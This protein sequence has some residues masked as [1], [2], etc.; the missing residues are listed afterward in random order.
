MTS[1]CT[2]H[3]PYVAAIADGE[4]ELVPAEHRQHVAECAGCAAE[5]AIQRE[6]TEGLRAARTRLKG[7]PPQRI[8]TL[9]WRWSRVGL[10]AAA[11]AVAIAAGAG[12]AGWRAAV[13][14]EQPISVAMAAAQRSP[15]FRSSDPAA[16]AEWCSRQSDRM[17]PIV[18]ITGLLPIGARLDRRAGTAVVTVFYLS[19]S[20]RHVA[21][22]WIDPHLAG[23]GGEVRQETIAGHPALVVETPRGTAVVDGELPLAQLRSVAG[24]LREQPTAVGPQRA[25]RSV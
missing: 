6:M 7:T 2:E 16:I 19:S 20:A 13:G 21:V 14:G 3:L 17:A 8:R 5:L 15:E 18:P 25:S 22:S 9:S 11:A 4:W 24:T 23:T 1:P 10:V 12:V